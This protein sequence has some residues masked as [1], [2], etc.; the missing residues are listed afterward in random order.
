[1]GHEDNEM[2]HGTGILECESAVETTV[3]MILVLAIATAMIAAIYA[4]GIP[5]IDAARHNVH[6]QS[7]QNH[8]GILQSDLGDLK[9]PILGVGP[10]RRTAIQMGG[11]TVT[12]MPDATTTIQ[13]RFENRTGTHVVFAGTGLDVGNIK[14]TLRG[15][16]VIYEN[17]AVITKYAVGDPIMISRPRNMFITPVDKNNISIHLR[18]VNLT[19]PLSSVG[20][21]GIT[22]VD[23]R[24]AGFDA[25]IRNHPV[26]TVL[27][28]NVT[29]TI[30]SEYYQ[31][32][33]RFFENELIRSGLTKQTSPSNTGFY[34]HTTGNVTIEIY[35]KTAGDDI[36]L[37]VHESV[38][39]SS[40]G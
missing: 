40:V 6:M 38:I 36:Y 20:G 14:Y 23:S 39:G 1:M 30:T 5:A 2:K 31:A 9:G 26:A 15:E 18:M 29:I 33:A 24:F 4:V 11:G 10:S 32:W 19:G 21:D 16:T 22:Y 12:V 27:Y 25:N 37:A 3:G 13:V 17:G 35:G 34:I 8:L 7:V 28:R